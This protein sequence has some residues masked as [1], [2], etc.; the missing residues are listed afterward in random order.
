MKRL[1]IACAAA[2]ATASGFPAFAQQDKAGDTQA[3]KE[4]GAKGGNADAKRLRDLALAN[5]AEIEAGKLAVTKA[6]DADVK[7]FAQKMVDDHG[8]QLQELQSLAQSRNVQLP[9]AP[10]AKHQREMKKLQDLSGADFDRAYMRAQ[11]KDHRDAHK[12]A[13][14]TAKRGKDPEVKAAAEKAAPEIQ[15]HLKMAQQ[16]SGQKKGGAASGKSRRNADSN[17]TGAGAR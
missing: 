2:F 1:L 12:L 16:I 13:E 8:K 10:D 6:S 9:T 11:I 7:K 14:S 5:L 3:S 17:Q 4:Q 15:D